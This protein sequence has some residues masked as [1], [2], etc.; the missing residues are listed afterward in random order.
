MTDYDPDEF[1]NYMPEGNIERRRRQAIPDGDYDS[2]D[3]DPE[4]EAWAAT[5]RV[6][7]SRPEPMRKMNRAGYVYILK[8]PTGAYK[9]G[10]TSD[11]D[12]RLKTFE[13]RLPFEVEY[14]HLIKTDD[15]YELES[16]LHTCFKDVCINREWFRLTET[17]VQLLKGIYPHA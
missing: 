1:D 11:P 3:I 10:R 6:K 9:I 8:S 13:V 17:E 16:V 12:N 14:E 15:M 2:T 7:K 4:W 5:R